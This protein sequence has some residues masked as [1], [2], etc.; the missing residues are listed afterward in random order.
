MNPIYVPEVQ[1]ELE[2][3]A[4]PAKVLG[5]GLDAPARIA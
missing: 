4:V 1:A 5:I 3:M 2:R